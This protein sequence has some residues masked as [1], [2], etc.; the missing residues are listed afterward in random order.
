MREVARALFLLFFSSCVV[1]HELGV[2][3]LF[4][5]GDIERVAERA[6]KKT[7]NPVVFLFIVV[8]SWLLD[9]RRGLSL[10]LLQ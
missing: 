1:P 5:G 4:G 2:A 10:P 3:G 9:C 6:R 7:A 8:F